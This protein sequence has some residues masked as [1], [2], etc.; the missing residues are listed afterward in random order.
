MELALIQTHDDKNTKLVF[1]QARTYYDGILILNNP[2]HRGSNDNNGVL[3]SVVYITIVVT[4]YSTQEMMK[5]V[6]D[7]TGRD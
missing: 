6:C 1:I 7:D 2:I 3:A 5:V 4:S